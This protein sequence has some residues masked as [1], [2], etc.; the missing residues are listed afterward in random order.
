M[1][2]ALA[3]FARLWL[4][5]RFLLFQRHRHGRLVLEAAGGIPIL[6]LPGVFNPSLF[7]TGAELAAHLGRIEIP[8]Q[9]R[10]LD[11]GTGSG[12]AALAAARH[13]ARVVAVDINPDAV[14]CARINVLMNRLEERVDV[15]QGDLFAPV[16]G[17][18]FDLVLFNPPF[19]I[20]APRDAAD[21]AWRSIDVPERF[22]SGLGDHLAPGGCALLMLS[23]DGVGERFLQRLRECGFAVE[24]IARMDKVNEVLTIYRVAQDE[25]TATTGSRGEDHGSGAVREARGGLKR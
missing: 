9:F 11:M 25:R 8:P 14:R 2:H 15:R 5:A 23:S 16:E 24:T 6:V 19:Y 21:R 17:E 10:V 1:R 12:I 22:A 7:R 18:R 13:G 3:P 4:R 20:G